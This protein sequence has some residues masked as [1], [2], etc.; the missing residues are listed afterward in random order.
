MA[1]DELQNSGA[2]LICNSSSLICKSRI[3]RCFILTVLSIVSFAS[4]SQKWD[5]IPN[6]PDLYRQRVELFKKEP[7]VEGKILFL[8]N[9]I[10]QGGDWRKL[11]NDST[12]INR[13]IG[14][15]ITFGILKRLDDVVKRKPSK[16]FLLIGINDISKNIPDEVIMENIFSIVSRIRGG[17]PKTQIYVQSIFPLNPS[18]EKFPANYDKQDHVVTL[19]TQLKKFADRL[20]YTFVDLYPEFLDKEN[21]LNAKYSTDGLHLNAAGYGHWVSILRSLK[22]V[23]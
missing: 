15:D 1:I 19:N 7:V 20:K 14:G 18:F 23:D 10:T 11:L 12:V 3:M 17:S 13:G 21:R 22:Y 9:S 8:G 16:V 4:Y 2:S 5:T 6:L